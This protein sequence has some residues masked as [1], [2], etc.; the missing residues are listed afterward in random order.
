VKALRGQDL[1]WRFL[2]DLIDQPID[3]RR[4]AAPS[5]SKAWNDRSALQYTS[6]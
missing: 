2:L 5:D 6:K 3:E 4:H 1:L